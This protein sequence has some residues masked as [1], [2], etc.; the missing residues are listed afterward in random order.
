MRLG[1]VVG[2]LNDLVSSPELSKLDPSLKVV[3]PVIVFEIVFSGVVTIAKKES[4][5]VAFSVRV[6]DGS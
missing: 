2:Q 3:T 5:L 6:L 4:V 1:P